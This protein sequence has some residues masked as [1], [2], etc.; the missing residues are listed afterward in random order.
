MCF[1]KKFVTV[2]YNKEEGKEVEKIGEKN[3]GKINEK[4]LIRVNSTFY[5]SLIV[6]IIR[7]INSLDIEL[8]Y[9]CS[10]VLSPH[11][12]QKLCMAV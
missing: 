6:L 2:N 8:M 4:Q 10:D 3:E 5:N 11:F 1:L 9:F 12:L 7:Q